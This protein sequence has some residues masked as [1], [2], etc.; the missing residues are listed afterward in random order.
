MATINRGLWK[1][2]VQNFVAS[3][4]NVNLQV[5]WIGAVHKLRYIA[6]RPSCLVLLCDQNRFGWFKMVL[7]DQID[8]DLTIMIWS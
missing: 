3:I 5:S 1:Q 6:E 4:R 7:V 8:L 2:L